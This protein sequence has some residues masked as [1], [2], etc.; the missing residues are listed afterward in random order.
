M[1][2]KFL[3]LAL[4]VTVSK[5][6]DIFYLPLTFGKSNL[7]RYDLQIG[8]ADYEFLLTNLPSSV[9]GVILSDQYKQPVPATFVMDGEVYQAE[10]RF[11]GERYGH[12]ER[13][14][15]SWRINLKNGQIR[16]NSELNF[17]I[18]EERG[19]LDEHLSLFMAKKMG[20]LVPETWF[21]NLYVNGVYQGVYF[22]VE[23][24][25]QDFLIKNNLPDGSEIYAEADFGSVSEIKPLYQS[26]ENWK[27]LI[28]NQDF[29][30]LERVINLL[31][32][33]DGEEF[34]SEIEEVLDIDS[35]FAWQAQAKLM[36]S[37]HQATAG[38]NRLLYNSKI[39]K[40]QFI[41]NDVIQQG[42]KI[43]LEKDTN[44][45][46]E[47][48]FKNQDY[49]TKEKELIKKYSQNYEQFI[50]FYQKTYQEVRKDI[51]R[52]SKKR[53]SNIMFD[54]GIYKRLKMLKQ[55]QEYFK[56]LSL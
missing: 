37:Y 31:K 51:Y 50:N 2:I 54:Y 9:E 56:G 43:E 42:I 7:P 21:A 18:P 1:K 33:E 55:R 13:E 35:F 23:Q 48:I 45:L 3:L 27:T 24:L 20:L 30:P 16:G 49:K 11:R 44:P 25:N 26:V 36:G 38:N 15:K 39:N 46:A 12:W 40:F 34:F 28:N 29:E 5:L 4:I 52:D 6:L 8:R 22:V 14:K 17:I 32:E 10:V 53:F 19:Y 41:P 47:R